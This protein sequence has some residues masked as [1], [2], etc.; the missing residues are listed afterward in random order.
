M[1]EEKHE[2]VVPTGKPHDGHEAE[3]AL[4]DPKAVQNAEDARHG[5]EIA[6]SDLPPKQ[7]AKKLRKLSDEELI[8]LAEE[9]KKADHW[10]DV[11]R[12]SQAEFDNA[13]KRI[14]R[15]QQDDLK[16]AAASLVRDLLPVLDNLGR[17]LQTSAQSKDFDA[18]HQGVS[19]TSKLFIDTLAQ[20]GI[21]PIE[22]E[23]KTF[24]P[25]VHEALMT[26]NNPDL[27][28]NVITMELE[29]GWKMLDR[30]LRASKVQVNKKS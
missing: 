13:V 7:R 4:N 5:E 9:A 28:D 25:A 20:R 27:D 14:K 30:V 18:L 24:D 29:R 6:D 19:M 21:T 16:Y 1:P 8:A 26:A 17:A 10:L 23:G 11:A 3:E 2:E 12:R 22:T 15:E